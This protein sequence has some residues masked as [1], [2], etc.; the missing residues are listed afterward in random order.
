MQISNTIQVAQN[1]TQNDRPM[2]LEEKNQLKLN[3]GQLTPDQQRG[4][5][6]IVADCINQNGGE[7]FEFEL[8]QLPPRKCREL[9][10]YVRKCI[11]INQK[12]EK[13][14]I[15]DQQRRLNQKK[16]SSMSQTQQVA[17]IQQPAY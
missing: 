4:I 12:K 1:S 2:N 15:A 11:S 9:E 5:I 3:I 10:T 16:Q 17:P 6:N 13:R 8:D 14:K 7:V